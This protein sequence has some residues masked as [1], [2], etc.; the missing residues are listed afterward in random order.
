VTGY[1]NQN[2]YINDPLAIKSE[3]GKAVADPEVGTNFS[4]PIETFKLAVGEVGWYG[5]AVARK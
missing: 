3:G 2:I 1:D 4:V 5:A